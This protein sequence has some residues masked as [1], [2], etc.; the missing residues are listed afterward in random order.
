[1]PD[2][3]TKLSPEGIALLKRFEGCRL[4]AYKDI[5]GVWTI[6]YG[7]T[8]A[9]KIIRI[10]P[11]LEITQARADQLFLQALVPYEAAVDKSLIRLATQNQFDAM[12]SLCYNIGQHAFSYS[13][14]V[15]RFNQGHIE[16]A[17]DAFLMWVHPSALKSRREAE[18]A[19]F[20][21]RL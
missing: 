9:A 14:V 19:F 15:K 4:R 1:M 7:L 5:V 6:G 2:R 13:T 18:R 3:I 16:L 8:N 11:G 12:G 10:E 21:S 17:A 20:L